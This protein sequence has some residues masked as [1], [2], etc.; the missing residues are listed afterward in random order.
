MTTTTLAN[1]RDAS[2]GSEVVVTM[3]RESN[4]ASAAAGGRGG[5]VAVERSSAAPPA[6]AGVVGT[7]T[8]RTGACRLPRP[9]RPGRLAPIPHRRR[10]F[11]RIT[12]AV[13]RPGWRCWIIWRRGGGGRA[14]EE[15]KGERKATAGE[16]TGK[17]RRPGSMPLE[18]CLAPFDARSDGRSFNS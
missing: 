3:C 6:V 4:E 12:V 10:P 11:R 2:E 18:D 13:A 1:S 15:E 9:L 16:G 5:G 17:R 8:R 7:N 14:G